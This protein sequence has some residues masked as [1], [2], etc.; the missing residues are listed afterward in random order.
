MSR[1]R[2]LRSLEQVLL[3]ASLVE[4]QALNQL[5]RAQADAAHANDRR[6]Q[7]VEYA[8][9]RRS[10]S[11]GPTEDPKRGLLTVAADFE[12]T[13]A[14]A[15]HGAGL[16]EERLAEIRAQLTQ[17]WRTRRERRESI[18]KRFDQVR[19]RESAK[20][21]RREMERLMQSVV[22]TNSRLRSK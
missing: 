21:Q 6:R 7:L 5:A 14:T 3:I 8:E 9:E 2:Q 16:E 15:I 1:S 18:G 22:L 12:Q 11:A 20:S 10:Q 13:L 4:N 17:H 19:Q